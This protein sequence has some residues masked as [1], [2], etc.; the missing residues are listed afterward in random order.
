MDDLRRPAT[1]RRELL[2]LTN[3]QQAQQ[4]AV[5]SEW[6]TAKERGSAPSTVAVLSAVVRKA[7]S[8]RSVFSPREQRL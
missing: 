7:A 5:R 6:T 3:V 8:S 1:G 4:Q 2:S